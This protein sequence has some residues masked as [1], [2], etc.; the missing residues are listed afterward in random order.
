MKVASRSAGVRLLLVA[1]GISASGSLAAQ[2]QNPSEGEVLTTVYPAESSD[3][4]ELAE[5]PEIEGIISARDG[6]TL[7]VTTADGSRTNVA[8][9]ETT[10]IRARGGFLGL[11]RDE[12]A[13][14]SLVNGLPVSVET[15]QDSGRLLASRI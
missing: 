13:A 10:R 5:G 7:Q 1:V 8:I 3:P 4:S 15:L 14:T 2:P 11:E 9:A 12:L 6:D